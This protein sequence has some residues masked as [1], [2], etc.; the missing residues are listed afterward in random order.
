MSDSDKTVAPKASYYTKAPVVNE[1][2]MCT[3]KDYDSSTG[4]Y[5]VFL[6]EY[7]LDNGQLMTKD[8]SAKIKR[9]MV[10]ELGTVLPLMVLEIETKRDNCIIMLSKKDVSVQAADQYREYYN[11]NTKL[12]GL[13]TRLSYMAQYSAT[14]WHQ[15]FVTLLAE[16]LDELESDDLTRGDNLER[17]PYNLL[18]NHEDTELDDDYVQV[19]ESKHAEL[20]G[21]QSFNCRNLFAIY[22]YSINGNEELKKALLAALEPYK[23]AKP[24]SLAQLCEDETR[25]NVTLMPVALPVF[26][27]HVQ[28]HKKDYGLAISQKIMD[29]IR[30]DVEA[31]AGHFDIRERKE[32]KAK[33]H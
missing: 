29:V 5:Q 33:K 25:C 14:E 32:P 4:I 22:L 28:S 30:R 17:H 19:I 31:L 11:L 23:T 13:A 10:L 21:M 6:N 24:Y 27:L 15:Q 20:F 7:G 18:A 12:F 16:Y 8:V 26:E 3:I 2:T 9:N 1:I